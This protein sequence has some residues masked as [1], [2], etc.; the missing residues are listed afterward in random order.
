MEM[1]RDDVIKYNE[2]SKELATEQNPIL[3]DKIQK[4][5]EKTLMHRFKD[6]RVIKDILVEEGFQNE[7]V[8]QTDIGGM[9]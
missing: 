9:A 1:L 6:T 3:K 5:I 7:I 2:L 4:E 8:R